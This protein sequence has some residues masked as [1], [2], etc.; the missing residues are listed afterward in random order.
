[1][2]GPTGATGPFGAGRAG[3][4]DI[5]SL[6]LCKVRCIGIGSN[7]RYCFV[8]AAVAGL[9]GRIDAMIRTTGRQPREMVG[10]GIAPSSKASP[11]RC[12]TGDSVL[13]ANDFADR[14]LN[15]D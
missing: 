15:L 5:G 3:P 6:G 2:A 4:A 12:R 10:E 9:P 7:R 8:P 1:L 13:S 11:L 14:W